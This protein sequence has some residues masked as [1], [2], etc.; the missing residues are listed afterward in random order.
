MGGIEKSIKDIEDSY[1]GVN[2]AV[3]GN[4]YV[5]GNYYQGNIRA[6]KEWKNTGVYADLIAGEKYTFSADIK[7]DT[8]GASLWGLTD[9][10]AGSTG[11][12]P[13]QALFSNEPNV[14]NPDYH[15]TMPITF[16]PPTTG[17]Y[18]F[19][20][21]GELYKLTV[22]NYF[23]N[24]KIELGTRATKYVPNLEEMQSNAEASLKIFT[25]YYAD[26]DL[27][28]L[29]KSGVYKVSG[30]LLHLPDDVTGNN[31]WGNL[32]VMNTSPYVSQFYHVF[33]T[34][35]LYIRRSHDGGTSWTAWKVL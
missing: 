19:Y 5:T 24:I 8:Y 7:P 12:G 2:L 15:K 29:I 1:V 10:W 26:V 18:Y 34:N 11:P 3:G 13:A 6:S 30:N 28:T 32:I 9:H 31:G 22:E 25:G 4:V 35:A 20:T 17:R 14:T 27:N 23:A 33:L 21:I 16:S